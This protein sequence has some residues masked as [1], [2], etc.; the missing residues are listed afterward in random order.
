M[1]LSKEDIKEIF[2]DQLCK[3]YSCSRKQL[4]SP[5]NVFVKRTL[6][7]GRRRFKDDDVLV[8]VLCIGGKVVF[9]CREDVLERMEAEFKDVKGEWF[10]E[11]PTLLKLDNICREYGYY[12]EDFHHFCLP[13]DNDYFSE[14]ELETMASQY[15]IKIYEAD[16]LECFRG[17]KRFLRALSFIE[18]APDMIAITA[19]KDGK[20]LGMSGVSADSENLW[21]IGIDVDPSARGNNIG[22][23]LTVLLKREV[24]K[25]GKVPFYGTNE[26]HIQS[27]RVSVKSGFIPAWAEL[28]TE[29]IGSNNNLMFGHLE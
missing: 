22:A 8:K 24:L 6:I 12:L 14:Q 25:R 16:E 1:I 2:I 19:S 4:V 23:L 10:S 9:A 7:D 27:Q 20:I 11:F 29:P 18:S 17:D 21:Q 13:A 26:S 5:N 3:D 15:E 28:N